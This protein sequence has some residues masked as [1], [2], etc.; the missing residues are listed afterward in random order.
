M[1]RGSRDFVCKLSLALQVDILTLDCAGS[2]GLDGFMQKNFNLGHWKNLF[3]CV[4]FPLSNYIINDVIYD[5]KYDVI[6]IHIYIY[7]CLFFSFNHLESSIY[8]HCQGCISS[9]KTPQMAYNGTP[10]Q[11]CH[12][13]SYYSWQLLSQLPGY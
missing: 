9:A 3:F 12:K 4:F 2:F 5:V 10:S 8:G 11:T 6:Y 1:G 7:I 13:H